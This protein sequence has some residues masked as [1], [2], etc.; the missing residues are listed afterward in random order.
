MSVSSLFMIV[1]FLVLGHIGLV[2]LTNGGLEVHAQRSSTCDRVVVSLV[3]CSPSSSSSESSNDPSASDK[4]DE[5]ES[6]G[7]DK[8]NDD[9]GEVQKDESG[10]IESKIPSTAGVPFP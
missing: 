1:I 3:D 10:D 4:N 7:D 9:K 2:S 5:K 8:D 6:N